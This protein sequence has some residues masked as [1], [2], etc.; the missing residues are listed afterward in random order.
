M[1]DF[2]TALNS[3]FRRK[4]RTLAGLIQLTWLL[5]GLFSSRNPMRLHYISGKYSRLIV[6]W[7]LIG[8]AIA[9]IGM[10]D[11]WRGL[12]F[13]GQAAFYLTGALDS[14]I[15]SGSAIKKITSPIRTFITL[16]AAALF[17]TRIFFVAPRSLWKETTVRDTV[18][19]Q[20]D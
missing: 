10:P 13:A 8:M 2:P 20:G 15:P 11:P 14:L 7:C 5:P 9:T 1:Y 4:V 12:V 6:P 19:V 18:Q 3:E 16:M 17:A